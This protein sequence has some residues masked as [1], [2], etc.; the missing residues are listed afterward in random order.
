M[1]IIPRAKGKL[2]YKAYAFIQVVE[3]K[4]LNGAQGWIEV[5]AL[6]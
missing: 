4:L 2:N 1:R 6:H 3:E 5:A